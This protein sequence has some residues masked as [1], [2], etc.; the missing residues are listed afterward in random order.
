MLRVT[1]RELRVV[2]PL[3]HFGDVS[4]IHVTQNSEPVTRNIFCEEESMPIF[5]YRCNACHEV[6]EFLVLGKEE[7][8]TCKG[9]GSE[10]LLKLMSAHSAPASDRGSVEQSPGGCCGTPGSCGSPG[11]C[12]SG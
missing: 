4:P 10:D 12:C 7:K 5:E 2:V 1:R 9:C 3:I 6:S 11:S 8:L